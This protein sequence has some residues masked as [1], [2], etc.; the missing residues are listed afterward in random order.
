[1][2]LFTSIFFIHFTYVFHVLDV[3]KVFEKNL[4]GC[5]QKITDIREKRFSKVKMQEFII[6]A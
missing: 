2:G 3:N 5:L 1:M 4:S 6:D